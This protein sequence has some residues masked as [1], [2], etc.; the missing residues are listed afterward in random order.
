MNE[1]IEKLQERYRLEFIVLVASLFSYLVITIL[2][3]L[4]RYNG[5]LPV[6]PQLLHNNDAFLCAVSWLDGRRFGNVDTKIPE[7]LLYGVICV[8]D[9]LWV[10]IVVAA[11][12][13]IGEKAS[14]KRT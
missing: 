9:A 10:V 3:S 5:W 11:G 13:L 12:K 8:H 4:D 14:K 7:I 1:F 2:M 6:I